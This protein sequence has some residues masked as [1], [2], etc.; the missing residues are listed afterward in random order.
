[1]QSTINPKEG[2]LKEGPQPTIV[3]AENRTKE[4]KKGALHIIKTLENAINYSDEYIKS[5]NFKFKITVDGKDY[6]VVTLEPQKVNDDY[7]W[8]HKSE[9]TWDADKEAPTYTIEEVDLPEGTEFVSANSSNGTAS[10]KVITGIL[11]SDAEEDYIIKNEYINKLTTTES[12]FLKIE[13]KVLD[14]ILSGKTFKFNV[15]INTR[16]KK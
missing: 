13:K 8:E 11:K 3:I 16:R 5:L 7:I 15:K 6:G 2:R 14:N 10:G 1:M 12:G 4:S 9:Y